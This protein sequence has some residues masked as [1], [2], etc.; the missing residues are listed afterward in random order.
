MDSAKDSLMQHKLTSKSMKT[1][2]MTADYLMH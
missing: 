1:K 2:S